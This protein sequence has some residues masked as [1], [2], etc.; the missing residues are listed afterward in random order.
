MGCIA[1]AAEA[2]RRAGLL[3]RA[4]LRGRGV[5]DRQL[6][7]TAH[8][9]TR[10]GSKG[11]HW[12]DLGV[13]AHLTRELLRCASPADSGRHRCTVQQKTDRAT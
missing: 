1:F 4:A 7:V 11:R 2:S 6:G 5:P 10:E 9:V 13:S 3:P 12:V 8:H